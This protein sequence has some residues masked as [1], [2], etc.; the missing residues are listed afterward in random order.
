MVVVDVAVVAAVVAELTV[1]DVVVA[2]AAV[3]VVGAAVVV[4]DV[5]AV[6]TGAAA[7]EG[8]LAGAVTT[9]GVPLAAATVE[10]R[11]FVAAAGPWW[12]TM[13]LSSGSPSVAMCRQREPGAV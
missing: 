9:A 12:R 10:A 11:I 5:G 7:V 1:V 13:S 3:V 2:G 6:T 8:T 4:L